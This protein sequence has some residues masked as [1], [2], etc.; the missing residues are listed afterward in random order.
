[1][2][3]KLSPA[4]LILVGLLIVFFTLGLSVTSLTLSDTSLSLGQN[5]T[6]PTPVRLPS[7]IEQAGQFC[8]QCHFLASDT[9]PSTFE[10]DVF[11][12]QSRVTLLRD[13]LDAI[14]ADHPD[15]DRQLTFADKPEQQRAIERADALLLFLEADQSWGFHDPTYAETILLE[16]ESLLATVLEG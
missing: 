13:T 16:T 3:I 10:T 8:G 6:T 4:V 1:M 15:W 2:R 9:P 5:Y 11:Q 14:H 7:E 12:L